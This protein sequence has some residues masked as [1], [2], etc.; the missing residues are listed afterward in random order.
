MKMTANKRHK[1]ITSKKVLPLPKLSAHKEYEKFHDNTL[2]TLSSH[3]ILSIYF[4]MLLAFD[5][6]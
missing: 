4:I 5:A 2:S 3:I 6:I 1:V